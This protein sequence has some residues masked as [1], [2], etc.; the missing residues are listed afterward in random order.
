MTADKGRLAIGGIDL[1]VSRYSKEGME[2]HGRD[3]LEV[4]EEFR[5]KRREVLANIKKYKD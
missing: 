5:Q 4:N 1:G 2:Q 3:L